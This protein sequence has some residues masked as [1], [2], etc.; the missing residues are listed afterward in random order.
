MIKTDAL[1]KLILFVLFSTVSVC[2]IS[3]A[4]A[5]EVN[6]TIG[7]D[8]TGNI[9]IDKNIS[10]NITIQNNTELAQTA[11][12]KVSAYTEKGK[13]EFIKDITETLNDS[14]IKTLTTDFRADEFGMHIL[15]VSAVCSGREYECST[16]FSVINAGGEMNEKIGLN[17]HYVVGR[18]LD[19]M[20]DLQKLYAEM[21]IKHA[22][23][24]I[25]WAHYEG[26]SGVYS[27]YNSHKRMLKTFRDNNQ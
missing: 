4:N 26:T 20:E 25:T 3:K 24:G 10:F 7:C 9:Y 2:G 14:E 27:L 19:K 1:K 21:G 11:E 8:K 22:R 23:E 12:I 18:G 16:R 17:S 5:A 13:L 6:I 15:K